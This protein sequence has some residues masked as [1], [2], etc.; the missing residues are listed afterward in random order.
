MTKTNCF[1]C[2]KDVP[3]DATVLLVGP[4]GVTVR[5][6]TRHYGVEDER[7]AQLAEAGRVRE[8]GSSSIL[9]QPRAS[10]GHVSEEDR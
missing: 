8:E 4:H 2:R 9:G 10:Q 5:A 7:Q 1:I 6:C 3:T